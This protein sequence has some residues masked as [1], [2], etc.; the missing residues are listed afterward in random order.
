MHAMLGLPV[1]HSVDLVNWHLLGYASERLDLG[2]EFRLEGGKEIYGQGIWAPCLRYHEGAFFI[3]SNVNRHTTQ[4]FRATN[5]AGPWTRTAMGRSFHDLSV[6]F[7]DDGKVYVIWGYQ[8]IHFAE[9]NRD[10]TDIV[11]G[12]EKIIIKKG[13]GIGEGLHWYKIDGKY[14]IF[15]AWYENRMWMPVN[16]TIA[17]TPFGSTDDLRVDHA[18]HF[19]VIDRG[20]GRV[21]LQTDDGSFVSVSASSADAPASLRSGPPDEGETF[22]WTENFYGDLNLLSLATHRQLRVDS[23]SGNVFADPPGP[24]PDRKDGSCLVW[25]AGPP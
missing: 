8:D 1:L 6:L 9:L 22:Q 16:R 4:L 10:L 11:A 2:P 7:D 3:F 13:A 14:Y 5:P 25:R 15:S 18:S 19:K 17:L 23:K 20:L 21:A 12:T 24:S